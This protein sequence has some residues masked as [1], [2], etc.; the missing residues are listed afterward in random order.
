MFEIKDVIED[1]EQVKKSNLFLYAVSKREVK[2]KDF[3]RLRN[4]LEILK[5]S[6]KDAKGKLYLSFDGYDNDKR[7]VYMIP[8]IREFVKTIWQEY[9]YLFYFLTLL[10]NNRTTIYA[11]LNDFKAYQYMNEK[12]CKFK[13]IQK[14]EI[15]KQTIDA[16]RKYGLIIDDVDGIQEVLLTF[17]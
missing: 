16:M 14:E 11:C 6:G 17:I 12:V 4:N 10:D 15:R 7:E 8:E 5:K 1:T 3:S 13:I 2:N 9:K